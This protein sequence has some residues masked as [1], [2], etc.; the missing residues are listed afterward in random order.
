M[1]ADKIESEPVEMCLK[2]DLTLHTS[3]LKSA[4]QLASVCRLAGKQMEPDR[5]GSSHWLK[6]LYPDE[7]VEITAFYD[8][9][10]IAINVSYTFEDIAEPANV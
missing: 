5:S 6:R 3:D 2:L 7:R 8:P 10:K 9:K 4:E 1:L